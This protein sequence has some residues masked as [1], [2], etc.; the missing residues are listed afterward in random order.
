VPPGVKGQDIVLDRTLAHA[1]RLYPGRTDL[2]LRIALIVDAESDNRVLANSAAATS[3]SVNQKAALL[4]SI[5]VLAEMGWPKEWVG[6]D[7]VS[8]GPTQ[9][10]PSEATTIAAKPWRGWGTIRQCMEIDYIIPETLRQLASRATTDNIVADCWRVQRWSA[11]DPDID[12][13]AFT[14]A[15]QTVNYARRV[16]TVQARILGWHDRWFTN[17]GK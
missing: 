12:P 9:A 10:S 4:V 2:A 3:L 1:R 5:D 14:A 6:K 16:S 17:G 11:A 7:G 8:V 15:P 13:V